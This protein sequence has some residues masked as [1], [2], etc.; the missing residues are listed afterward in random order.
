[1][2]CLL[3]DDKIR[4]KRISYQ[5]KITSIFNICTVP[6]LATSIKL[7]YWLCSICGHFLVHS[8]YWWEWKHKKEISLFLQPSWSLLISSPSF[9]L[10]VCLSLS[11]SLSLSLF[12][13]LSLSVS[14]SLCLSLIDCFSLLTALISICYRFPL[15]CTALLLN[16][17]YDRIRTECNEICCMVLCHEYRCSGKSARTGWPSSGFK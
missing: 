1:M 2:I 14:L 3:I 6:T 11:L 5:W 17:T 15:T 8:V 16:F 12:L 13:S 4:R 10:S 9:C 7:P